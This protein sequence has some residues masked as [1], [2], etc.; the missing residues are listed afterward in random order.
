MKIS[1]PIIWSLALGAVGL[2]AGFW[3][4]ILL[5][6]S[7]NQG[8]FLGLFFTGPISVVIGAALGLIVAALKVSKRQNTYLLGLASIAIVAVTLTMSLPESRYLGFLVDGEIRNCKKPHELMPSRIDLWAASNQDTKWRQPRSGWE[9][10]TKRML[11]EDEGVVLE[12][13]VYRESKLHENQK[14]WNKGHVELKDWSTVNVVKSFY[15]R[16]EGNSCTAYKNGSRQ[17]YFPEWEVSQVSPP[18]ILPQFL[19]LYVLEEI[20]YEYKELITD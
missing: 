11:A 3:G 16:L 4:P 5:N 13:F 15:A 1:T 7:A 8:P 2:G 14:P 19:G 17:L 20:P 12:L 6:P 10:D 18:D 9:A